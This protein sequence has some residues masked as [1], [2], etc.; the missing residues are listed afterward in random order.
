MLLCLYICQMKSETSSAAFLA[1]CIFSE[2][3][4]AFSQPTTE[5]HRVAA[6]VCLLGELVEIVCIHV[7]VCMMG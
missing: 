1:L 4:Q 5:T 2:I 6:Q 7:C 3:T